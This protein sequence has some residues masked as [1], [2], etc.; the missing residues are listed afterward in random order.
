MGVGDWRW[1]IGDGQWS[2]RG[3]K[4]VW[5][6]VGGI[7]GAAFIDAWCGVCVCG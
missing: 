4:G 6:G 7:C 1:A 2:D 3:C 5:M